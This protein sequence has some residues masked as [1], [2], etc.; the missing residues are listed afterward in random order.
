MAIADLS[1]W[2]DEQ[3]RPGVFWY[4]KRLAGN[5][6]LATGSHQAGPYI[7]KQVFFTVFPSLDRPDIVNPDLRFRLHIDSHPDVRE[8]RAVWYNNKIR[9]GTRDESRL[10]GFGGQE[11][12]L[13]DPESTGAIALFCFHAGSDLLTPPSCH[14]WVC[15]DG[16]EEDEIEAR[17]GPVEPG[18]WVTWTTDAKAEERTGHSQ[19]WLEPE[20]FP[21][22]WLHSF[23]S[24]LEIIQKAVALRPDHSIDVDRRIMR[25]RDC[26]YELFRSLEQAVELPAIQG[27]FA[28]VEDFVARAQ[29]ILQRRKSR[30]GRSLELHVRT[31]FEE[32][33]LLDGE[34]FSWQPESEPGKKPDFLFPSAA[35]Y[36]NGAFPESKLRMLA[37]KTSCKDRWRQILNE[38]DRIG[39]KH[40][41]TLQEG[42]SEKQ[43]A[44]MTGAGVRLVVPRPLHKKYPDSVQP[45]LQELESFLGDVRLLPATL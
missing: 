34:H 3:T 4:A 17:I 28:S 37:V 8:I 6:T 42:V 18:R 16:L 14:V 40:L 36:Q 11:S 43:F 2:L 39:T 20:E 45:H 10:T 31:I 1:D 25:R 27:G 23:P 33:N 26:E 29:T 38:A 35:A 24:G 22:D 12:A 30:S 19:C 32:E 7:P 44:E 13:L 5:D 21:A 9:G 15:R 41:F